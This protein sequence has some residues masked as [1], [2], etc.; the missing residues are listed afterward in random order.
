MAPRV[1]FSHF[2]LCQGSRGVW[3]LEASK[4]HQPSQSHCCRTHMNNSKVLLSC[5]NTASFSSW[6]F[7]ICSHYAP[8]YC[9]T[10]IRNCFP[11]ICI[12][13]L[14]ISF[15]FSLGFSKAHA[16]CLHLNEFVRCYNTDTIISNSSKTIPPIRCWR[17]RKRP[18]PDEAKQNQTDLHNT[19]IKCFD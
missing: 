17:K 7:W 10:M 12:H 6:I 19:N 18:H 11:H 4:R 2:I 5:G 14:D 9:C 15:R 3:V 16:T 8:S 13:R 1:L